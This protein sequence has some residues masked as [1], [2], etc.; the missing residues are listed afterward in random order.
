MPVGNVKYLQ[1]RH[2]YKGYQ[3]YWVGNSVVFIYS[4]TPKNSPY[5]PKSTDEHH[6]CG[7]VCLCTLWGNV[8]SA[9][10]SSSLE[11]VQWGPCVHPVVGV[12]VFLGCCLD[13][14]QPRM[15]SSVHSKG[16]LLSPSVF[17]GCHCLKMVVPSLAF[18]LCPPEWDRMLSVPGNFSGSVSLS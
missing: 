5:R 12:H 14:H 1:C 10:S 13:S 15:V 6:T 4:D 17:L 16:C 8:C 7:I 9:L 3:E 2:M 18:W 11:N